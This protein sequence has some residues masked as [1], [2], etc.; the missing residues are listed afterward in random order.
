MVHEALDAR[1]KNIQ[2]YKLSHIPAQKQNIQKVALVVHTRISASEKAT[3]L[4]KKHFGADRSLFTGE[5][6]NSKKK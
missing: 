2:T 6:K 3:Q 5:I 1:Q 4:I